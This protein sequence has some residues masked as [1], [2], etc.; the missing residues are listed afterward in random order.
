MSNVKLMNVK[1]LIP[2]REI[3]KISPTISSNNRKLRVAGYARVSSD[4]NDQLNSFSAQVRYYTKT[5]EQNPN[6]EFTE[7]YADEGITG[8]STEKR[9]DFNRMIEDCRKGRV[10][11]IITKS[12]S[13][14]ARN[15]MD[16]IRI[17]RE[18]KDIGVTVFFEKENIDTANVTSEN[19]ITLY[20]LF[21]QEESINISKNCK[22]VNR[23]RMQKGIYVSANAPYGY[24]LVNN[25]LEIYEPEAKIVRRIFAEYL[26]GYSTI[27][28]AL[29]LMEAGIPRKDGNL[30]WR[31]NTIADIIRNERYAGDMLLQKKFSEDVIPYRLRRNKGELPKYYV[32][33]THA[34]IVEKIQFV[35]AN[36]LLDERSK[37]VNTKYG[38]YP[39]MYKIRCGECNT[40]Y[41]RQITNGKTYW[42]C[43]AHS[44]DKNICNSQRIPESAIY[45]SFIQMY[46]KLKQNYKI[47]LL[48]MLSQ[49]EKLQEAKNRGNIEISEI[50]KRIAELSEQNHVMNGLLTKGI[51]DSALFISQT[52]EINQKIRNLKLTKARLLEECTADNPI[53]KTE[54]LIEIIENSQDYIIDMDETLFNEIV[55]SIVAKDTN[56]IDFILINGLRLI[57]RL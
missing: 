18:L 56:S 49:L 7:V 48:P 55:D 37:L 16:T 45:E 23:I 2:Q 31:Y 32:K 36:I 57:E 17:I 27:K 22:K 47:I 33:D 35:L 4:S 50:N 12:T 10:D 44:N 54:E 52:D 14:F 41:R 13:R 8:V 6:W 30:K 34:P 46:N 21:A 20:A 53:D 51:L 43:R 28:I 42:V 25:Q 39:L 15:T 1:T 24:R 38:E 11:R 26:G 3:I 29:G 5:I 9:D 19:L 40:M